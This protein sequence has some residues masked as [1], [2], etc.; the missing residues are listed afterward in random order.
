MPSVVA[1]HLMCQHPK[2]SKECRQAT[3]ISERK[4]I[5]QRILRVL[6]S[7]V[8]TT[9]LTEIQSLASQWDVMLVLNSIKTATLWSRTPV[10]ANLKKTEHL[11]YSR[12]LINYKLGKMTDDDLAT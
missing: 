10:K 4:S 12:E 6:S 3:S 7:M 9:L 8:N 5:W 2:L 1:I 11:K